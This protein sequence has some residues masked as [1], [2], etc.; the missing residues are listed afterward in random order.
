MRVHA[1]TEKLAASTG[2][3]VLYLSHALRQRSDERDLAKAAPLVG[4]D[5]LIELFDNCIWLEFGTYEAAREVFDCI[6]GDD[7]PTKTN[8]YDGPCRVYA[9]LAGPEGGITENT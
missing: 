6:V 8:P 4:E 5:D 2:K 7:G 1:V 9:Y 3:H